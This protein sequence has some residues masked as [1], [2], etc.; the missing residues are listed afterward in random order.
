MG[1][2]AFFG[3][4]DVK[5]S[6]GDKI[7]SNKLTVK[8][9]KN[10]FPIM[11]RILPDDEDDR[12]ITEDLFKNYLSSFTTVNEAFDL[13]SE[14][15]ARASSECFSHLVSDDEFG[16]HCKEIYISFNRFI[17]RKLNPSAEGIDEG[18]PMD[19]TPA[20]GTTKKRPI[21]KAR[22]FSSR[23]ERVSTITPTVAEQSQVPCGCIYHKS[24]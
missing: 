9:A 7:I 17:K 19:T 12:I 10:H 11:E 18:I 4:Q 16:D 13:V 5:E 23:K 3:P 2:L 8:D 20:T 24:T 14:F 22:T 6:L 1:I 15:M 21:L